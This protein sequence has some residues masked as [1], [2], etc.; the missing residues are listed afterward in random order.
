MWG[1]PTAKSPAT[2]GSLHEGEGGWGMEGLLSPRVGLWLF[3][4]RPFLLGPVWGC[5]GVSSGSDEGL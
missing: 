5:V 2:G 4:S 1:L 3:L